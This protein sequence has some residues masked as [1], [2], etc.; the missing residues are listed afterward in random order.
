MMWQQ[1]CM[2]YSA[3]WWLQHR[4]SAAPSTNITPV[5]SAVA[6]AALCCV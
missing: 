5:C 3:Q 4:D 1:P 2:P 6:D